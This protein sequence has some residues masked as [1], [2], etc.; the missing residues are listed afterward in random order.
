VPIPTSLVP[1]SGPIP[2]DL[3]IPVTG[4]APIP[5]ASGPLEDFVIGLQA[6]VA[7][8]ATISG[9]PASGAQPAASAYPTAVEVAAQ[10]AALAENPDT[11]VA[12]GGAAPA[13]RSPIY[14]P[15]AFAI[16]AGE[17]APDVG[18]D[19]DSPP[20][21]AATG[22]VATPASAGSPGGDSTGSPLVA[23]M[24]AL[25]TMPPAPD[26][27]AV[28]EAAPAPGPTAPP[29]AAATPDDVPG[30]GRLPPA[31]PPPPPRSSNPVAGLILWSVVESW[32]E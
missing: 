10:A 8:G 9:E 23:M 3:P 20:G 21:P 29:A 27:E 12:V 17:T 1:G 18:P 22:S 19:E 31:Q 26:P 13:R 4:E 7:N 5:P 2:Y 30:D 14:V 11:G 25:L 16:P 15:E 6:V 32:T 24:L 28:P